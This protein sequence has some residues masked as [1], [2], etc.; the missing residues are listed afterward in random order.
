MPVNPLIAD[1]VDY[2]DYDGPTPTTDQTD[3]ALATLDRLAA[4]IGKVRAVVADGTIDRT[5]VGI[6]LDSVVNV[7][8]YLTDIAFDMHHRT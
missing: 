2:D 4:Q 3:A 8:N 1:F 6:A 5:V 7:A